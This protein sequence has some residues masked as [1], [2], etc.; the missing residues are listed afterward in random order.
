MSATH[1]SR[2]SFLTAGLSLAAAAPLLASCGIAPTVSATPK[3][4]ASGPVN[5]I[6]AWWGG[7]LRVQMTEQVMKKFSRQH[8]NVSITAQYSDYGAY[9]D[10][11]ATSVAGGTPADL[12]QLDEW[13]VRTYAERGVLQDLRTVP[14]LDTSHLEAKSM[15]WGKEGSHLYT[16]PCGLTATCVYVNV[17]LLHKLG[18][19]LPDTST[20]SWDD[21][22]ALG[23]SVGKA[24]KGK[25]YGINPLASRDQLALWLRQR[26][27]D[28]FTGNRV[29]A[30]RD[31]L[32]DFFQMALDWT[33]SGV[34]GSASL[35][36]ENP[37]AL[38]QN[39][40]STGVAAMQFNTS[41]QLAAYQA[42]GGGADMRIVQLPTLDQNKTRYQYVKPSMSWA[43]SA[44]SDHRAEA[45]LLLNYILNSSAAAQILKAERGTPPNTE[46]ATKISR[47][48]GKGDREATQFIVQTAAAS[49]GVP[50]PTPNGGNRVNDVLSRYVQEVVFEKTAPD[51]AAGSFVAELQSD[52]DKATA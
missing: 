34:S 14:E 10:K 42:A 47:T 22:A 36:A 2:R 33:K 6:L 12:F 43:I 4:L 28:L 31:L 46:L 3:P 40:F 39:D 21:L 7:A 23:R 17:S 49:P 8:P 16:V 41:N 18:L 35:Q 25:S 5:M 37:P 30:P 48:L 11:L 51:D 38:D 27:H 52:I 20:W 15:A 50:G 26:G 9:F 32:V 24:S 45:G 13:Y 1:I 44:F 29:S 19:E